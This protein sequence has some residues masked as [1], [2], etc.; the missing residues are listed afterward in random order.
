MTAAS[1][2]AAP[3][4]PLDAEAG[5]RRLLAR[6]G[7]ALRPGEG[8]VASL[9]FFYFFLL[10]GSQYITRSVRDSAWVT[11]LDAN[12][13]PYG[14]ILVAICSYPILVLFARLVDRVPRQH[15]IAGTSMLFASSMAIFWWL[16]QFEEWLWV[17][18]VFYVWT[19]I[20]FVL[21]VSQF[22][23]YTNHSLDP[24]QAK[25]LFGF[26]GAGGGLGG[27]VGGLY[28]NAAAQALGTRT[29]LLVSA[30]IQLGIVALIYVSTRLHL[31]D[32]AR[33]A[34]A[35]GLAK[36]EAA[37][38]GFKTIRA[39]RQL[40]L[41]GALMLCT[42]AVANIVNLQFA[43]AVQEVSSGLDQATS[44]FA[45]VYS[46]NSIFG[47]AFHIFLTSRIHRFLGIGIA[48]R[49]LPVTLAFGTSAL[50]ITSNLFPNP[51]SL[52][53]VAALLLIGEK[54]LRYSLDQA[55]RELLFLP[56]PSK[57]RFRAKAYIDVFIQ[58]SAKGIGA[59]VALFGTHLLGLSIVQVG[60][61]TLG[62]IGIWLAVT[63]AVR[64]QFVR[65]F[66]DGLRARAVDVAV[67]VDLSDVTSLE[68]MVQSLGSPDPRQVKHS[69]ELLAYHN[70]GNLVPPL[71]LYHDNSEVKLK[72]LEVIMGAGRRDAVPIIERLLGD[73]DLD[74][75][76]RAVRAL[77]LL[78]REDIATIMAPRLEDPDPRVRAAA[79]GSILKQGDG[80]EA[81]RAAAMLSEMTADADPAVR[82]EAAGALAELGEPDC[83]DYL[84]Q[85]LYDTEPRVVRQAIKAVRSRAG[86]G[87]RNP[88]F[89]PILISLMR[90]R[91]LKH[92]ARE[93]LAACGESVIPALV[94]FMNDPQEQMWVRRAV[95]K[96]IARI[97]E[98]AA[99]EA[100]LDNLDESD[101][102]LRRKVV[103]AL[104]WLRAKHPKIIFDEQRI[105]KAI[106]Q[107]ARRYFLGL[108]DLISISDKNKI[109]LK[110]LMMHWTEDEPLLVQ[111]L[112]TDRMRNS[113]A[114]IFDMLALIRPAK[115]IRAA[116]QGLTGNDPALRAHALEYLDNTLSGDIHRQVF[117]VI[118]D[119]PLNE[120]ARIAR[121][122]YSLAAQSSE[123]VLRRLVVASNT[124]DE[125][126]YWLGAAAVHAICVGKIEGLYPQ[127]VETSRRNDDSV[128]QETATWAAEYLGL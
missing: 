62:I 6:I 36:L 88:I 21:T 99:A 124:V 125:D 26:I 55:T 9:L 22:W 51:S 58:R 86:S 77:A 3:M 42:V 61:F 78:L 97:G 127:I 80:E 85:L 100:L 122:E 15:L 17:P 56:V 101:Q 73:E 119:V 96:T 69:L 91:R 52:F 75:R 103:E 70:K 68:M 44:A 107:E 23:S 121:S 94:H 106:R 95:P 104:D 43:G 66:R 53:F 64:R 5:W 1:P 109:A 128:V 81:K 117:S 82:A 59:A 25:R 27:F 2:T 84:V 120:K 60:W 102:F 8:L 54:G 118:N 47:F 76:A 45:L 83:Q 10:I 89:V 39:S 37:R 4:S 30:A 46:I 49:I 79:I 48:M 71:I 90:D 16:F 40:M 11:F 111:E 24:R 38:G 14:F 92:D 105:S 33:V 113:V 63:V 98:P 35:A 74:V 20:A 31:V 65:S 34:G 93:T 72:A 29:L 57:A 126:A 19:S 50:M 7:V 110:A 87:G 67:P 123:D 112:L 114:L 115:D 41:I 116:Y 108:T 13:L 32:E 28:A 18:V 12:N